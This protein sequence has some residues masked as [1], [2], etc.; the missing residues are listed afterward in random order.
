MTTWTRHAHYIERDDGAM[1]C[2]MQGGYVD[3]RFRNG[4]VYHAA[5]PRKRGEIVNW[6]GPFRATADEAK[7]DLED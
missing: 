5:W 1:V 2:R 3:G 4:H 6:A 7:R